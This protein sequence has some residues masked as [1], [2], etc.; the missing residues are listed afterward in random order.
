[1]AYFRSSGQVVPRL[2]PT[3]EHRLD[4]QESLAK[5]WGVDA[6]NEQDLAW[7]P[8]ATTRADQES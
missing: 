5:E 2:D 1:M 3:L 8:D 6:K 4:K 7:L